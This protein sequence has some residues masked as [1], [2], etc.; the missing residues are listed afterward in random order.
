MIIIR[1]KLLLNFYN[2]IPYLSISYEKV[3]KTTNCENYVRNS[4]RFSYSIKNVRFIIVDKGK[5]YNQLDCL[6]E[7]L[8]DFCS[9]IYISGFLCNCFGSRTA[10]NL[11]YNWKDNSILFHGKNSFEIEL[12]MENVEDIKNIA[13]PNHNNGL[14]YLY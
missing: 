10:S 12:N 13:N 3:S 6:S 8:I 7:D 1:Y 9:Q 5:S 14:C 4:R 2:M 11:E